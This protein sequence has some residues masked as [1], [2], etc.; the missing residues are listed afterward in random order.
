MQGEIAAIRDNRAGVYDVFESSTLGTTASPAEY[1][2]AQRNL[3]QYY[4]T[5]APARP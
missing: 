3:R 2:A 1:A 5:P 4:L